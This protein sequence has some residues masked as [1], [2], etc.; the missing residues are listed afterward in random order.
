MYGLT[1]EGTTCFYKWSSLFMIIITKIFVSILF[2]LF[3]LI[4]SKRLI[5]SKYCRT[6]MS[7]GEQGSGRPGPGCS[8]VGYCFP[9]DNWITI[10]RISVR[11]TKLYSNLSGAQENRG[12]RGMVGREE[13]AGDGSSKRVGSGKNGG[14][15]SYV[16]RLKIYWIEGDRKQGLQSKRSGRFGP[17]PFSV[18][19]FVICNL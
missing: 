12:G 3:Y 10:Q 6:R 8:Y 16:T 4:P 13:R 1:I 5:N 11:K 7:G 9:P 19:K 2:T 15:W 18:S 14:N 17:Q